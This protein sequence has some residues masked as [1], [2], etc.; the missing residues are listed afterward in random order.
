MEG[1]IIIDTIWPPSTAFVPPRRPHLRRGRTCTI[2]EFGAAR[3]SKHSSL[4][5]LSFRAG[6]RY[7]RLLELLVPL[8]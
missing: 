1:L 3:P 7:F 2:W 6:T 5:T 8:F 4:A